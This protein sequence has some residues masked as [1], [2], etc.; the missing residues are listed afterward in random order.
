[1][2]STTYFTDATRDWI[3]VDQSQLLRTAMILF[4]TT[5]GSRVLHATPVDSGF[6]QKNWTVSFNQPD[7]S[8]S[9]S[10]NYD[11]YQ[12]GDTIYYSNPV[13]YVIAVENAGWAPE[14]GYNPGQL[15][16]YRIGRHKGARRRTTTEGYSTQAPKGIYAEV[17]KHFQEDWQ[18]AALRVGLVIV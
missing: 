2:S 5:V 14:K 18:N 7:M 13:S 15:R 10:M 11:A 3:L 1:M 16:R 17:S 4:F 9:G 8:G 6:L 12:V